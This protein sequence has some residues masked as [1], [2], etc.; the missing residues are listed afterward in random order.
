MPK[1]SMFG[2]TFEPSKTVIQTKNYRGRWSN[3]SPPITTQE[4][5]Q[6]AEKLIT[7]GVGAVN[8]D[9]G[10]LKSSDGELIKVAYGEYRVTH[11]G[12]S[13][14]YPRT[15]VIAELNQRF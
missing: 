9:H 12:K 15:K 7:V 1:V 2:S 10:G 8:R 13:S 6:I 14:G 11:R 4:D 5:A 3:Y